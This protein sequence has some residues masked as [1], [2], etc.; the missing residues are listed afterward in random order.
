MPGPEDAFP[1]DEVYVGVA[2]VNP[3]VG[4]AVFVV[5]SFAK[6]AEMS[7][8]DPTDVAI[9]RLQEAVA[10]L[11][12][13]I[14]DLQRQVDALEIRQAADQ[15]RARTRELVN[16]TNEVLD[17]V[18]EL[19]I[20]D[21]PAWRAVVAD[22]AARRAAQILD[23][24][25]LWQFTD[26]KISPKYDRDGNKLPGVDVQIQKPDFKAHPTLAVYALAVSTY[27]LAID[28]SDI[29]MPTLR[30]RHGPNLAKHIDAVTEEDGGN[31]GYSLPRL[32]R[33]R[34]EVTI[35]ASTA[36]ARDH[37]CEYSV[38]YRNRMDRT[39]RL[40]R[41]YDART[42]GRNDL[43]QASSADAEGDFQDVLLEDPALRTL[44]E[45][46]KIL[47]RVLVS[48]TLRVSAPD[49]RFPM[50]E[51]V[52]SVFYA[53]TPTLDVHWWRQDLPS[54]EPRWVG[55]KNV[56]NWRQYEQVHS[57]G[58][59]ILYGFLPDGVTLHWLKHLSYNDGASQWKGPVTLRQPGNEREWL[60]YH[61]IIPGGDGVLYALVLRDQ[62]YEG[63]LKWAR[64]QT[65]RKGTGEFSPSVRVGE[66]WGGKRSIFSG[67]PGVLYTVE[68]S[69]ALVWRRHLG[70]LDG[71]ARWSESVNIG[72]GFDQYARVTG[73]YSGTI[74]AFLASGECHLYYHPG[75]RSGAAKLVGPAPAGAGWDAY[76]AINPA[77][78]GS[79]DPGD[80]H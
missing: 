19:A 30:R 24:R 29:D 75:W 35:L 72:S 73:T 31:P 68:Q 64:H 50:W 48:G 37:L 13:L 40:L 22:K 55:P 76:A 5:E 67:G 78:Y 49:G 26:V 60:D 9:E 15:N 59:D 43:C 38:V 11:A 21:S 80:V 36:F 16:L 56:G 45:L 27:L 65:Y 46:E 69:G 2:A 14:T 66:G 44:R 70:Y 20:A 47:R 10:E 77:V 71:S 41:T 18:G 57:A 25:D 6:L 1:G 8:N 28:A 63:H 34:I 52:R 12:R 54:Q 58:G 23:D 79:A 62:L 4:A 61:V 32:V 53:V 39:S 74:Y 3:Y 17:L 7:A 51:A 33:D 42:P